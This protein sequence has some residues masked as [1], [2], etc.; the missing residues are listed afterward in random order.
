MFINLSKT[1]SAAII[2]CVN[3]VIG[4]KQIKYA[5]IEII[6]CASFKHL[7]D[8]CAIKKTQTKNIRISIFTNTLP[9]MVKT[10]VAQCAMRRRVRMIASNTT[11]EAT[12]IISGGN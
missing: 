3:Q 10:A 12:V 8:V 7:T 6:H 11:S 2:L 1:S 4:T 5:K 9:P